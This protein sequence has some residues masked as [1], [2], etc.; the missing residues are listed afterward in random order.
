MP[1]CGVCLSVCV[2]VTFVDHVKTNRRIFEL[3]SPSGSPTIPVFPYQTGWRYSDGSPP[4]NG[5]VECRWGKQRTRFCTN[6]W[7]CCI[8]VY[9]VIN[10]TTVRVA[11][12]VKQS[13]DERWQTSS[14]HRGVRRPLFAQ[15]DGEVF[16]T[17]STLYAGDEGRSTPALVITPVF[18]CR[19]TS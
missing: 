10:R 4:P 3:F 8:Q 19:R 6:I 1:S 17:G 2:S 12:C 18:C 7:L 13:R 16:V 11:N 15:E 9:S 5:S 14:T